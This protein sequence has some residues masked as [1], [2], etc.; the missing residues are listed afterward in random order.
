MSVR[1]PEIP[2]KVVELCELY[3]VGLATGVAPDAAEVLGR[4]TRPWEE[5]V[6]DHAAAFRR[7][8]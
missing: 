4:P 6:A 3:A 2:P 5:F 7:G 1:P 8:Q